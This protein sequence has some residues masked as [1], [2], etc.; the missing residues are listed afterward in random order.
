[1]VPDRTGR[2]HISAEDATVE[3]T[4]PWMYG[5]F[6][7]IFRDLDA[8]QRTIDLLE[9]LKKNLEERQ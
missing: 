5:G 7:I 1:M 9:D 4:N 3:C 6:Y 8:I 2:I